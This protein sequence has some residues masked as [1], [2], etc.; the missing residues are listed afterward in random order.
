MKVQKKSKSK[1]FKVSKIEKIQAEQ[2]QEE[3][4]VTTFEELEPASEEEEE[5][6]DSDEEQGFYFNVDE[7]KSH[8]QQSD[9]LLFACHKV[10]SKQ[11][12]MDAQEDTVLHRQVI[13]RLADAKP[14]PQFGETF[15][16][17]HIKLRLEQGWKAVNG[18]LAKKTGSSLFTPLQKSLFRYMNSYMDCYFSNAEHKFEEDINHLLALHTLNHVYKTRDRV[19]KNNNK[20]KKENNDMDDEQLRDQGFT[21]PKV[22]V[23]LPFKNNAYEFVKA[24]LDISGTSQQVILI[25]IRITRKD[26]LKCLVPRV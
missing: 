8:L 4:A 13:T 14:I 18:K 1:G 25:D 19:I 22:L 17:Y 6:A 21:R 26:F 24:V 20:L 15:V 11:V 3:D 12:E 7:F 10:D 9:G 5:E 23:L 2:Q 16:S